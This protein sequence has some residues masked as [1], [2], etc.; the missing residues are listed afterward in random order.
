MSATAGAYEKASAAAFAARLQE[1][2]NTEKD[3]AS[4]WRDMIAAGCVLTFQAACGRIV[5]AGPYRQAVGYHPGAALIG[6]PYGKEYH[7]NAWGIA[8]RVVEYCGRTK[9]LR[10]QEG[11]KR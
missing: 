7:D 9:P 1:A 3:R 5:T 6:L 11:G 8:L 10:V 2:R 4:L